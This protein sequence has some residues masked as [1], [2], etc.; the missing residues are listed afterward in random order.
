MWPEGLIKWG[1]VL[2]HSG[3]FSPEVILY[4]P[5]FPIVQS[6]AALFSNMRYVPW[7]NFIPCVRVLYAGTSGVLLNMPVD[8]SLTLVCVSFSNNVNDWAIT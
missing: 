7:K 2:I 1:G 3:N 4:F 8:F 6:R 5:I